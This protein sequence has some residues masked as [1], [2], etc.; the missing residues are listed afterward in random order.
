M[1]N[2]KIFEIISEQK[3]YLKTNYNINKIGVF[4]S[5]AIGNETSKSDV[6]VL[7]EF[8]KVPGLFDFFSIQD[9]LE[10]KLNKRVDLV[11]KEGL[12]KQIRDKVLSEVKYL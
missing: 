7:V 10:N 9:Y 3:E 8:D 5:Y 2:N 12:K 4:G 6:D 11:R 1:K